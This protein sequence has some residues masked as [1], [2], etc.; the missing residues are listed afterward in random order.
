MATNDKI[1]DFIRDYFSYEGKEVERNSWTRFKAAAAR[2]S[3]APCDMET[4]A[5]LFEEYTGDKTSYKRKNVMP[6]WK[7]EEYAKQC[8]RVADALTHDPTSFTDLYNKAFELYDFWGRGAAPAVT[9]TSMR[10]CF[11][12]MAEEGLIGM[13]EVK[14]CGKCA[15]RL[16]YLKD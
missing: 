4:L 8:H 14:T 6:E 16:Y 1:H 9:D 12:V 5:S 2:T 11:R 3:G 13:I 7:C 15:I 10:H